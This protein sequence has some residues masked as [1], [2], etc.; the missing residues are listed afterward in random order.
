MAQEDKATETQGTPIKAEATITATAT[1][2]VPRGD[3]VAPGDPPPFRPTIP[4][5]EHEAAKQAAAEMLKAVT[6]DTTAPTR[7]G[8]TQAEAAAAVLAPPS[9]VVL[10]ID[11]VDQATACGTCRPPDTHGAVGDTHFVEVTNSHVDI[12]SKTGVSV[13]SISLNSFFNYTNQF[14]FDP[15]VVYDSV[16]RRWIITADAFQESATVQLLFIGVSL[17]S[18]PTGPFFIYAVNVNLTGDDFFDYPQLG[19]DQDA[20]IITAN[21]FSNATQGLKY[22]EMFAVA[23]ARLYN[24]LG[25]SVPVFTGLTATLAPP[26]V[27]DQNATTFLVAAP[28]TGN[29]LALYA[30]RDLSRAFGASLVLQANVPVPDYTIPASAAQPGTGSTLDTLDCRFVNASTQVGDSLWQVHSTA[31]SAAVSLATPRF[32]EINT[33]TNSL[34]QTGQFF[35]SNTSHDWN[36]SIAANP[37]GEAFVDWSSTDPPNGTNPQVRFS[38]RQPS[39]P[40]GVI[41]AGDV[42]C[43]SQAA[44]DGERWGDYSAMTL[45]PQPAVVGGNVCDPDR[46]AWFVNEKVIDPGNWGTCMGGISFCQPALHRLWVAGGRGVDAEGPSRSLSIQTACHPMQGYTRRS[47]LLVIAWTGGEHG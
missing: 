2:V 26:I 10:S 34:N 16:W 35:A 18:D 45:D 20:V 37:A 24:G 19:F 33:A 14:L 17:T 1:P 42:L 41:P 25:F 5:S 13:Q 43:S 27:S 21:I 11:G 15:R 12:Y 29:T 8:D 47:N 38:G 6:T 32:Y 40:S 3:F 23:K 4:P 39:D 30:A 44:Y 28:A 9:T 36:A 22:A 46:T 31:F 7:S